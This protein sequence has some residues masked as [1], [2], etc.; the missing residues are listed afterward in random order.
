LALLEQAAVKLTIVEYLNTP[1][2]LDA[3]REMILA[4][5]SKPVDFVRVDDAAFKDAGLSLLPAADADTVAALLVEHPRLMQRPVVVA[6]GK[7]RIGRP[8]ERVLEVVG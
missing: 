2:G 7:V 8:P 1:P 3:L 4:S 5:D 6:D